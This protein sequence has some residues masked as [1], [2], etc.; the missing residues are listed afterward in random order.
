MHP[1]TNSLFDR[2]GI[3][4]GMRC[5]DVGCGS[6]DVTLELAKRVGR[7]GVPSARTS[8]R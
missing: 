7:A 3:G 2:L 4:D 8:T 5:L 6:G 1:S